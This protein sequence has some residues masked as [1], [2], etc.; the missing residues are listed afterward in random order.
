MEKIPDADK[1][2]LNEKCFQAEDL[3]GKPELRKLFK[4][5]AYVTGVRAT[6]WAFV[7]EARVRHNRGDGDDPAASKKEITVSDM[8]QKL[9]DMMQQLRNREAQPEAEA[10]AKKLVIITGLGKITRELHEFNYCTLIII[11]YYSKS[12]NQ[13]IQIQTLHKSRNIN[14]V[15]NYIVLEGIENQHDFAVVK[16]KNRF[17]LF[18]FFN[19]I[20]FKHAHRFGA[21]VFK[22]CKEDEKSESAEKTDQ[23]KED[24]EKK[25]ENE[26]EREDCVI[27]LI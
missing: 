27:T 9:S 25:K 6:C 7:Q 12:T 14:I 17:L 5:L 11:Y 13:N 22:P 3:D 15:T 18:D 8:I 4:K 24:E 21:T 2:F 26:K 20:K 1:T 16:S 10:E 23:E 19:I